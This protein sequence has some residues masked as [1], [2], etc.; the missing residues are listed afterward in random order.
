[1]AIKRFTDAKKWDDPW[2]RRLSPTYKNFWDFICAHCDNAGVWKP[3]IDL[4]T[5]YVGCPI[6]PNVL[7][8]LNFGKERIKVLSNE[9]WWIVGY[10][11]FQFGKDIR[12]P[13]IRKHIFDLIHKYEDFGYTQSIPNGLGM[14]TP[15][16]KEKEK[17]KDKDKDKI[18]RRFKRPTIEQITA[19]CK[20]INSRIDPEKFFHNYESSGWVKATGQKIVN[21]KSTIRTWEQRENGK[22]QT[23]LP[24]KL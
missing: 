18:S 20:E 12:N 6:E 22:C 9:S 13:K 7:D 17:E 24:N 2:Y 21:W 11:E 16:E 23:K 1:M 15:K 19:Y 3:D 14:H 4:A 10:V 8:I 5:F